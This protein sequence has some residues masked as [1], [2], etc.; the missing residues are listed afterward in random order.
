MEN[1]SYPEEYSNMLGNNGNNSLE[2]KGNSFVN[3][4]RSISWPYWLLFFII[5]AF[6]GFNIFT[7]ISKGAGDAGSLINVIIDKI[8]STGK[9]VNTLKNIIFTSATATKGIIDTTAN[10]SN[11]ILEK[12]Q[13]S[14]EVGNQLT[15][16][17]NNTTSTT[18]STTTPASATTNSSVTPTTV[19]STIPQGDISQ[20]NTLNRALNTSAQQSNIG[21]MNYQAD[22]SLSTIQTGGSK[23]GWCLIGE[24][25]G[26]R[27]CATVENASECMS[28]DIFPSNEICVNPRL[29]T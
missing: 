6:L 28:G 5:L 24:D 7:V 10:V 3:W 17:N 29:R 23:G 20:N 22:D 8:K 4:I 16:N 2:T 12:V 13:D 21:Q 11:D 18:T 15:T 25:R 27:S 26:F 1:S 9:I 14:T 19:T